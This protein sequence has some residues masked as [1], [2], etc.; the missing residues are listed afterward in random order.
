MKTKCRENNIKLF[1][2]R[3]DGVVCTGLIRPMVGTSGELSVNMVMNVWDPQN[4]WKFFSSCASGC[5]SGRDQLHAVSL[6]NFSH[7]DKG[8]DFG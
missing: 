8:N 6:G 4:V 1:L 7:N 3:W 5:F 2:G